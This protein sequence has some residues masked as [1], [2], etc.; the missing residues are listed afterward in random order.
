MNSKLRFGFLLA[1]IVL[2]SALQLKSEMLSQQEILDLVNLDRAQYG[3][4]SLTLNPTLNL[5]ALAKAEDMLS[6]NYF[7]HTSPAGTTPWHW[8]KAFGYNY[9]Y[10][11]ENLAE[12]YQAADELQKSWMASDTHRANILSPYYSDVGLAVVTYNN[13]NLV[14][15]MFGSKDIRVTFQK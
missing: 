14:V 6:N 10:A 11:G 9:T 1:I 15:Q 12:G 7:A 3:L 8:L 2:A 13:T 4:P 5:A